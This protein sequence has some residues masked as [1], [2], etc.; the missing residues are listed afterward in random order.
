MNFPSDSEE[1][2]EDLGDTSYDSEEVFMSDSDSEGE[3]HVQ[4][5]AWARNHNM[6]T[7]VFNARNE[8]VGAE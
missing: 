1:S 7:E 2:S 5:Y 4:Q 3:E 6:H 8:A